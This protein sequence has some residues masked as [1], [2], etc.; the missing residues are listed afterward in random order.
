MEGDMGSGILARALVFL[1]IAVCGASA[2]PGPAQA[3]P[4]EKF[5]ISAARGAMSGTEEYRI[6]SDAEGHR[7]TGTVRVNQGGREVE[8]RHEMELDK[9]W[10][11]RRYRLSSSLQGQTQGVTVAHE[12]ELFAMKAE[13]GSQATARAVP[14]RANSIILD[15][16]VT[17]HYQVFLRRLGTFP[18]P[19]ADWDVVVP[20]TLTSVGAKLEESQAEVG[21]LSGAPCKLRRYT[22]RIANLLI[23]F[24][25]EAGSGRLMRMAVPIQGVDIRREGFEPREEPTTASPPSSVRERG[26]TIPSGSL[27]LPG[28]LAVPAGAAEKVP[29]VVLVHGSGPHD[30]DETIGPNKPFRDLAHGL[31]AKGIATLRYDK[32]TFALKGAS[33]AGQITVEEEVLAD[34]VSALEFAATLPETDPSGVFL[35]GHSLGGSMAPFIAGRYAPLR[36]AILLA[37][38]ARPLDELICE[39][40]AFGMKLS[41]TS[42]QDAAARLSRMKGDFERVRSGAA[43]DDELVFFAPARY[44]RHLFTMDTTAALS[45]LDKPVLVLQGAKDV[46]VRP[47]DYDLLEKALSAK[48]PAMKELHWIDGLNHLFIKVEGEATAAE[49]GIAGKVDDGVVE[50]IS[51]WIRSRR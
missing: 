19:S 37:A 16:L 21:S 9:E 43:R 48:P 5:K 40:T 28:T 20:Q 35:L 34:A 13:M 14:Y 11:P 27:Q 44:W 7:V 36:G 4:V 31:A 29:V 3:G 24:W 1:S 6:E 47:A 23:N 46:Q 32:R 49:Y 17:A 8:F 42:E 38:A 18:N 51:T 2:R 41:G 26:V 39:Q 25:A 10:A 45:R 12:G 33:P 15:N 22:L 30:R 50:L